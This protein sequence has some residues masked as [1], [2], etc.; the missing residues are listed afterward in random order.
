MIYYCYL[1]NEEIEALRLAGIWNQAKF[2]PNTI[3]AAAKSLQLC[4]TL[5]G[6][7]DRSPPGSP[8]LGF[9]RQEHWSGLPCSFPMHES[10]SEVAQSCPT[11]SN[12]MDCS[13]PGSPVNGIFQA[14]VLEWGA[15]AFSETLSHFIFIKLTPSNPGF[16]LFGVINFSYS[17]LKMQHL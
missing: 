5:C 13:L 4:P 3:T 8:T 10:E 11:L 12:P 6:P 14:R 2:I 15:I 16:K 7:I 1:T 17:K 9:S